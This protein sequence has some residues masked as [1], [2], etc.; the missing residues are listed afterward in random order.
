MWYATSSVF[1]AGM[2]I[3]SKL[4][5]EEGYPVWEITFF[6]AVVVLTFSL[7]VLVSQGEVQISTDQPLTLLPEA[8]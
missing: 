6:R 5:G 4:L 8:H 1:F 2:G 3:C 7:A